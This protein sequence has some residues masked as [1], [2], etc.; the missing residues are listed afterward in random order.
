MNRIPPEREKRIR[1]MLRQLT[2]AQVQAGNILAG[3]RHRAAIETFARFCTEL[4]LY[5]RTH[6]DREEIIVVLDEIPEIQYKRLRNHI[7]QYLLIPNWLGGS[8]K[9]I[10]LD[11]IR[12]VREGYSRLE[13]RLRGMT[14]A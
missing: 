5:I 2:D 3:D 7:W 8:Q 4:N 14:E 11:Q 6:A 9:S 12:R 10:V 13:S 1:L